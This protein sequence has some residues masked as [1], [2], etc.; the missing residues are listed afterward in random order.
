MASSS[1]TSMPVA[2]IEFRQ[3]VEALLTSW[4][5]LEYAVHNRLGG[6]DSRAKASWV[7]DVVTNL[8][9]AS[10]NSDA[11]YADEVADYLSE[12][13]DNEF[14][15][16]IED[17]SIETTSQ[18]LI[19]YWH[20]FRQREFARLQ[21]EIERLSAR[22]L[23]VTMQQMQVR[24]PPPAVSDDDE[25]MGDAQDVSSDVPAPP[26]HGPDEDGWTTVRSASKRNRNHRNSQSSTTAPPPN[27][28]ADGN[29]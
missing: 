17:G 2:N 3:I 9:I 11:Y 13:I 16:I 24:Q 6:R 23:L 8:F 4:D 14:S 7:V 1:G 25:P 22:R 5:S 20:L 21:S 15:T 26:A 27:K 29:G 18:R 19:E 28:P 12:L 10:R